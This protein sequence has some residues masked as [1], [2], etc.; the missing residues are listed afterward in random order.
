[1]HSPL[2]FIVFIF[3]DDVLLNTQRHITYVV[4]DYWHHRFYQRST[5]YI[6]RGL[7]N[8]LISLFP[9]GSWFNVW[10][11]FIVMNISFGTIF[12]CVFSLYF[13]PYLVST[14]LFWHQIWSEWNKLWRKFLF[15][16]LQSHVD[17]IFRF[18]SVSIFRYNFARN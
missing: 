14:H 2:W 5:N 10:K 9:N 4:S 1:M 3:Y 6:D 11:Y 7:R 13:A 8:F 16:F 18:P 17:Y 15:N 12:K